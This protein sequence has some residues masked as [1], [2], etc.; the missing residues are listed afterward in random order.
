MQVYQSNKI[1]K[2]NLLERFWL[3]LKCAADHFGNKHYV[4]TKHGSLTFNQNYHNGKVISKVIPNHVDAQRFGIGLYLKD[5]LKIIP[6]MLGSLMAGHYFIPLDTSYPPSTLNQISE[7]G[8]IRFIISDRQNIREAGDIFSNIKEI[9]NIDELDFGKAVDDFDILYSPDD[10]MQILFTS[11][12]TGE[13]KGAVEDFRYLIR[14]ISTKLA[15]NTYT[16]DDKVLQLSTFSYSAPHLTTFYAMFSGST[17]YYHDLLEDGFLSLPEVIDKEE[18]NVYTS[19]V[20]VFRNFL[21]TLDKGRTFPGVR[22][23][24]FGGEKKLLADIRAGREHFPNA[25]ILDLGFAS[26]ETWS[27]S[28][29]VFP[30]DHPFE[31]DAIPSGFPYDDIKLM[32][33]D[34]DGNEVPDGEEGEIV[35]YGEAFARG[36]LNNPELT[37]KQFI[38]DP[39]NPLGQYFKT[40]D[41]GKIL[42]DGQ[43][44]HLGRIDN[45][46][47]IKGVRI[48]LSTL[49]N[50]ILQYPGVVQVASRAVEDQ[51]GDKKLASYFIAEEGI[52]IPVS[53]L[54]HYLAERL[55]KHQLPHYL[56]EM[57]EF[58]LTA[59]GKVALAKLPVP[60]TTRPDLPNACVA[61]S[62]ELEES[63]HQIW[64]EQLGV[65]GVGVTDDFFDVGGD[66]LLGVLLVSAIEETLGY[67]FPVSVL[68]EAP[69]IRGQAALIR[70][71]EE[72]NANKIIYRIRPD[73]KNAPIFFIP[74][75]G[76]YPTRIKYLAN[77]IDPETPVYALQD[78]ASRSKA[79]HS[80]EDKA[81]I[82]LSEI[83][84][85]SP[86]HPIILIGE[87]MGGK[88]AYEM[89][90]QMVAKDEP[91]PIL[92]MLDTYN[93]ERSAKGNWRHRNRVKYYWGLLQ[94]HISHLI[95]SDWH[96]KVDYLKYY[97]EFIKRGGR[98]GVRQGQNP[99]G[100]N[101]NTYLDD[102]E[103]QEQSTA[104]AV[105]D[106]EVKP[107][108]GQLIMIK[109]LRGIHQEDETNGWN[110]VSLGK[111]I[112]HK[113]DC[114]HGAILFEPAVD[115]LSKIINQYIRESKPLV[116][117]RHNE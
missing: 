86:R 70:S 102:V 115:H 35:V 93:F 73:G 30:V 95:K 1:T 44:L 24:H 54:R 13:P 63:L 33:W 92:I 78:I 37:R 99:Q 39:L 7:I 106:Y 53:D 114:Y 88:I 84:K 27:V 79:Y 36:Y 18:I 65:K 28:K 74:G 58:P 10:I 57:N 22:W 49:E 11:G 64:E 41:Q 90:Q 38:S 69:T 89:A 96:G 6:A 98:K 16:E 47:K 61:P 97:I 25:T 31:E 8:D 94:K 12:S 87:S 76:V 15:T 81:R 48:E 62:D 112:V 42:P 5:P 83:R 80:I 82:F 50:H 104:K 105:R 23:F 55:P 34:E 103:M 72:E 9:L 67:K 91:E 51:R 66:S 21:R 68:I 56:V 17:L 101:N 85:S 4:E 45:M 43:L 108:P 52:R 20:T 3:Y 111:L 59:S 32:I 75:R 46:V 71:G 113:L 29:A 109:A 2:E 77:K 19:T 40:G 14:T 117:C 116:P 26:T 60:R 110:D 100:D 107:Y